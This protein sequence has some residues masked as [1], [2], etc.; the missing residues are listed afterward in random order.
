MFMEL[1]KTKK[2][3][4]VKANMKIKK[5]EIAFKEK[6]L[7]EEERVELLCFTITPRKT[8]LQRSLSFR[9]SSSLLVQNRFG[10]CVTGNSN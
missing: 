4:M 10:V 6:N 5:I 1:L 2:T 7:A 9:T 3:Q 8:D